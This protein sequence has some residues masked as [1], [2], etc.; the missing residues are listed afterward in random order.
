MGLAPPNQL[1]ELVPSVYQ[2]VIQHLGWKSSPNSSI[3]RTALKGVNI[4]EFLVVDTLWYL[5]V[6]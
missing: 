5:N 4:R 2:H 6:L 1:L 3:G